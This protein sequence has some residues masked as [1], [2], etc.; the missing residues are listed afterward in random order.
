[1][2][3]SRQAAGIRGADAPWP[4]SLAKAS[5]PCT[6]G[7]TGAIRRIVG[8]KTSGGTGTA[9]VTGAR[10]SHSQASW[11]GAIAGCVLNP[12]AISRDME[13]A[14]RLRLSLPYRPRREERDPW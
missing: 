2:R 11:N 4:G 13:A 10:V 12:P 6:R 1:M 5:R 9:G 3:R 7:V 8:V 14:W